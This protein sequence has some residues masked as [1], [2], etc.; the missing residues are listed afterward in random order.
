MKEHWYGPRGA[1]DERDGF[2]TDIPEGDDMIPGVLPGMFPYAPGVTP[3]GSPGPLASHNDPLGSW[4]GTPDD[5]DERPTQ[6]AD[7]L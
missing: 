1:E 7:D 2:W 6:D 5:G 3:E 4:T